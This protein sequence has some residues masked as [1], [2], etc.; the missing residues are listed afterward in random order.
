MYKNEDILFCIQ[1]LFNDLIEKGVIE[2]SATNYNKLSSHVN[3]DKEVLTH[4][5]FKYLDGLI[6]LKVNDGLGSIKSLGLYWDRMARRIIF[7]LVDVSGISHDIRGENIPVFKD[8]YGN[9]AVDLV[10]LKDFDCSVEAEA[11]NLSEFDYKVFS[12]VCILLNEYSLVIT[13]IFRINNQL[14]TNEQDEL[15]RIEYNDATSEALVKNNYA[16]RMILIG[17]QDL[18]IAYIGLGFTYMT[19]IESLMLKQDIISKEYPRN[20]KS[21]KGRL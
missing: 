2:V 16:N 4:H 9:F 3:F 13:S 10:K 7:K 11:F 21:S 14:T 6:C 18:R 8:I 15:F 20:V 5:L 17:R 19:Y 12:S 1:L